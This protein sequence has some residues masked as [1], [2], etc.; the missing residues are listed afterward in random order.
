MIKNAETSIFFSVWVTDMS[1]TAG[2]NNETNCLEIIEG[3]LF[4]D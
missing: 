4:F 3:N 2:T 1:L